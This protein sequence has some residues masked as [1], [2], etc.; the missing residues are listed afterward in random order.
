MVL[1][2]IAQHKHA[3]LFAAPVSE[4]EAPEY[5]NN[6]ITKQQYKYALILLDVASTIEHVYATIL[7]FTSNLWI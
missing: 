1:S 7:M 3:S 6:N 2:Q 4:A 5:R